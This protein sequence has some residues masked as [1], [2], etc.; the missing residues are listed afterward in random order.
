V[1]LAQ[2]G[3]ALLPTL[4]ILGIRMLK[5]RLLSG[6]M[7]GIGEAFWASFILLLPFCLISGFLLALFSG[8]VAPMELPGAPFFCGAILMCI[9]LVLV[10]RVFQ[11]F[12]EK[13]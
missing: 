10:W 12:P 7:M 4:Q 5:Q 3:I 8:E 6:L 1:L 13:G 9:A 2:M 11:R